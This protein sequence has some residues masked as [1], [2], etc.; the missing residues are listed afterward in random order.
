MS[1]GGLSLMISQSVGELKLDD[2][3]TLEI[4]SHVC[5]S[6]YSKTESNNNILI[7]IRNPSFFLLYFQVQATQSV[8]VDAIAVIISE[9]AREEFV[10]D[11][12]VVQ[13]VMDAFIH[14][15]VCRSSN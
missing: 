6:C 15:K 14:L 12:A 5:Y 1:E 2:S 13:F 9:G 11:S 8:L 4:M 7:H 3:S 10:K